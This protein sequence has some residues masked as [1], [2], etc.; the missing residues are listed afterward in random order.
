MP[1]V[2]GAYDNVLVYVRFEAWKLNI[3][4]LPLSDD[5][6]AKLVIM[7]LEHK[8]ICGGCSTRET[9]GS[10]KNR[11]FITIGDSWSYRQASRAPDRSLSGSSRYDVCRFE[12]IKI[13]RMKGRSSSKGMRIAASFSTIIVQ[14]SYHSLTEGVINTAEIV[15]WT[16]ASRR[17]CCLW[18]EVTTV[19]SDSCGGCSLD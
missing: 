19:L 1:D 11:L 2:I 15:Q 7:W 3:Q 9:Q 13:Y 8:S 6:D 17:M 14:W 4:S 12:D 10:W 5:S 18:W 16:R